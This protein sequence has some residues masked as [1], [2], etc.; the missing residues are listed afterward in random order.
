MDFFAINFVVDLD[1]RGQCLLTSKSQFNQTLACWT[2]NDEK[3][4]SYIIAIE[5]ILAIN[6][7]WSQLEEQLVLEGKFL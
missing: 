4:S 6:L 3:S 7:T 1:Q 2:S 5:T